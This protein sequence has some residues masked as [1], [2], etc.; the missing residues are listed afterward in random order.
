MKRLWAVWAISPKVLIS[1]DI[2]KKTLWKKA[3][4]FVLFDFLS[5]VAAALWPPSANILLHFCS[6]FLCFFPFCTAQY[7]GGQRNCPLIPVYF[8]RQGECSGQ[9]ASLIGQRKTRL[10]STLLDRRESGLLL[11]THTPGKVCAFFS[12][13]NAD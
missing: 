11:V 10:F 1:E 5:L 6:V 4:A 13:P 9:V 7:V 2:F 8:S 12:I 3:T